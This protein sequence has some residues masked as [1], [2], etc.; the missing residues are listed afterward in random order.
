MGPPKKEFEIP[1]LELSLNSW[2]FNLL[3]LGMR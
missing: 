3:I 2:W 1:Y